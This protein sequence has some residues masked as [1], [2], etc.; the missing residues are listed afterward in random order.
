MRQRTGR[1]KVTNRV[2]SDTSVCTSSKAISRVFDT[3]DENNPVM[4][5]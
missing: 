4:G 2:F 1:K 3:S 5:L